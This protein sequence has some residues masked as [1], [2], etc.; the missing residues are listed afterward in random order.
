MLTQDDVT[1]LQT[2]YEMF[3]NCDRQWVDIKTGSDFDKIYPSSFKD[4]VTSFDSLYEEGRKASLGTNDLL[5][6]IIENSEQYISELI[7]FLDMQIP[8]CK[9]ASNEAAN[10]IEINNI[11]LHSV[12]AMITLHNKQ[13]SLLNDLRRFLNSFNDKPM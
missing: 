2:F 7:I 11:S 9:K 12:S 8:K 10:Q 6:K 1:K 4:S 3:I 5:I 13:D